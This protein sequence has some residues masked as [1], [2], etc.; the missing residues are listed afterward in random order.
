MGEIKI[1]EKNKKKLFPDKEG[2]RDWRRRSRAFLKSRVARKRREGEGPVRGW[3]SMPVLIYLSRDI[4]ILGGERPLNQGSAK[5]VA[6]VAHVR[7]R[8]YWGVYCAH[9]TEQYRVHG[10]ILM[11]IGS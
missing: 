9:S 4:R 11:M 3:Q 1:R 2:Q 8:V 7:V 5:E 10:Y 6:G